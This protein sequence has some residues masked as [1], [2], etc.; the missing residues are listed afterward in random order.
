MEAI[1]QYDVQL[2]IQSTVNEALLDKR[3][4]GLDPSGIHT[5]KDVYNPYLNYNPDAV[6]SLGGIIRQS[7]ASLG[8]GYAVEVFDFGA[9]VVVTVAYS[10]ISTGRTAKYTFLITFNNQRGGGFVYSNVKRHRSCS[11]YTQACSYIKTFVGEIASK[12]S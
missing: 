2:D 3:M 1:E 9:A 8:P 4:R 6:Y 10:R 12:T 11:D 7:L 5:G